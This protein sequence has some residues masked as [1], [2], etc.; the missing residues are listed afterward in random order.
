[1]AEEKLNLPIDT[2]RDSSFLNVDLLRGL[3]KI[4]DD[5]NGA[6]GGLKKKKDTLKRVQQSFT[7]ERVFSTRGVQ[8]ITGILRVR[9][10]GKPESEAKRVVFKISIDLDRSVEHEN[11]ITRDLNLIRPFCP[12]FVGNV[13]MINIP[14]SNDFVNSPDDE[15]LFKNNNDYFPCNVLLMEYVS[16]ISF[17]H[18]CKYL[19][20]HHSLIIS[21]MVMILMAM[22]VAQ[23]KRQFVSYDPHMDNVLI[24]QIEE[25]ALFLYRHQGKNILVPTFGLYP[26]I[27]DLGSSYVKAVEGNPMYTSADNYHNGLQPTLFDCLNDVHH[28][29]LSSLQYLEDKGYVYDFL[30]T[31]F[32]HIFRHV[33]ILAGKGWKQLPYDILDLVLKKIKRDVP[34]SREVPVWPAFCGEIVEI[35]NGLIILPWIQ[36]GNLDFKD[37][38]PAFLGEL[39]KI[40]DMKAIN[41]TDDVLYILRETVDAINMHRKRYETDRAG[42]IDAFKADWKARIG[43]II[44]HNMKEI[45]KELDFE[46]LFTSAI[47]VAERLSANYYTYVEVHAAQISDAY[48]QTSITCPMDAAKVMLQHA[49]PHFKVTRGNKIYVWDSERETKTVIVPS[50]LTDKQLEAIDDATIMLKGGL[51]LEF[52]KAN[53]QLPT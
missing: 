40:Q 8:G 7:F 24:R 23:R 39:Q 27:I 18:V 26:V 20:E 2:E 5:C 50:S 6:L 34:E 15:S 46:L 14:V 49:T 43:F 31:R 33:P 37:C 1:M 48:L 10:K 3:Q 4:V 25:D 41:S 12:H 28:L 44:S 19:H 32:M 29:L 53:G 45:P 42:A 35:V 36:G 11:I 13:G 47:A 52:L 9:E 22:D 51:L 17:Y 38:L 21:Q 30:R 16:P